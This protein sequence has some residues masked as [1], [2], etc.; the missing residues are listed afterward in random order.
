MIKELFFDKDGLLDPFRV[1]AV[2]G[3]MVLGIILVVNMFVIITAGER[4]VILR[5]GAVQN[6]ILDEGFHFK[7]PF[8]ERIK[9][10][11]VKIQKSETTLEA[12][13]RDLQNCDFTIALNYHLDPSKVNTIYQTIGI[14]F[15]YRIIDPA[16]SE[17]VKAVASKYTAE[18]LITKRDAVS[19]EIRLSLADKLKE[20]NIIVDNFSVVNFR[21]SDVFAVSIEAKQVAEQNALKAERDLQ[22]IKIEAQQQIEQ[23]KAEAKS[24]SLKR[25]EIT[26]SLIKLREIEMQLEAI[27]K[28]DGVLPKVSSGAVPFINIT[29]D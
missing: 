25:N 23:A 27:K 21:F 4:G 3:S 29:S 6:N 5:L 8:V 24:L 26:D 15:K 1:I 17:V 16:V 11:D 20:Y 28:W 19:K 9:L 2:V 13:T 10:V 7:I 12:S 18:S 22:R 14:Q